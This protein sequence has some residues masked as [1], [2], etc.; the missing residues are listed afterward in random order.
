MLCLYIR[1]LHLF[2]CTSVPSRS[3]VRSGISSRSSN[4][5]H[6]FQGHIMLILYNAVKGVLRLFVL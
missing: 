3:G 1:L 5:F 2:R 6:N 4:S